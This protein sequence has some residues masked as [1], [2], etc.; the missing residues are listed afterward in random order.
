MGSWWIFYDLLVYLTWLIRITTF[1]WHLKTMLHCLLVNI[2]YCFLWRIFYNSLIFTC[3][4]LLIYNLFISRFSTF[5]I[6]LRLKIQISPFR[7]VQGEYLFGRRRVRMNGNLFYTRVRYFK[8]TN[9]FV[10]TFLCRLRD[11]LLLN[12]L[13]DLGNVACI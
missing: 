6:M 10:M 7:R 5:K 9:L 8:I 4:G 13:L 3:F 2:L 1:S 11:D 12:R